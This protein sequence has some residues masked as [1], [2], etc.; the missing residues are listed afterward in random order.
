MAAADA[1]FKTVKVSISFGL[2]K[3]NGLATPDIEELP[4][5]SFAFSKGIPSITIKGSLL[6]F[7]EAPPRIRITLPEPGAPPLEVID[8][9]ATLPDI[10]CSG[11]AMLPP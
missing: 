11:V 4:L 5:L 9:P 3:L 2:I 8:T 7:K 10:N 1:S 6:A